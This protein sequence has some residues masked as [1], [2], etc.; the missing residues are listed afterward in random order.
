MMCTV[1]R[2]GRLGTYYSTE[3]ESYQLVLYPRISSGA[4]TSYARRGRRNPPTDHIDCGRNPEQGH[5]R[6][7]SGPAEDRHDGEHRPRE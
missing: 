1:L 4:C 5:L 7:S 2:R 6:A 3:G